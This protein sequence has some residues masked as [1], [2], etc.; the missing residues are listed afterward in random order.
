MKQ[1]AEKKL[2]SLKSKDQKQ[3]IT[4]MFGVQRGRVK[5]LQEIRD[6]TSEQPKN[7]TTDS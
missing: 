6:M 7:L 1:E 4:R 2:N 5:K 3:I